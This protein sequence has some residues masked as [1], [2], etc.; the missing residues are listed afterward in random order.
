MDYMK[1]MSGPNSE[2]GT[3]VTEEKVVEA[4]DFNEFLQ[5]PDRVKLLDSI[6][7]MRLKMF[8]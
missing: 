1:G 4:P 3:R 2:C 8:D 5:D 6:H 7:S